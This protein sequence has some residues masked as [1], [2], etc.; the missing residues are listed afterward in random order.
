MEVT[1]VVHPAHLVVLVSR[2]AVAMYSDIRFSISA[3]RIQARP[4]N[5]EA[6]GADSGTLAPGRWERLQLPYPSTCLSY[7]RV[8]V[9]IVSRHH[10]PWTVGKLRGPCGRDQELPD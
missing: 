6:T 7:P 5:R 9:A 3:T 4:C 8:S 2:R 10:L 1:P